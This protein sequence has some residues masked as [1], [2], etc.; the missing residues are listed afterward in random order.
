MRRLLFL[1]HINK[2]SRRFGGIFRKTHA[3]AKSALSSC[4]QTFILCPDLDK[5]SLYK[6]TSQSLILIQSFKSDD[7]K[8]NPIDFWKFCSDFLKKENFGFLYTRFSCSENFYDFTRS[9]HSI[10][11]N[12]VEFPTYPFYEECNSSDKAKFHNLV[13]RVVKH[14]TYIFSPS[15]VQRIF[16]KEVFHF[17][18]DM[19][20]TPSNFHFPIYNNKKIRVLCL[21]NFQIWHG[22]DRLLEGLANYIRN[23]KDSEIHIDFYGEG[24]MLQNLIEI[25]DSLDLNNFVKFSNF[26]DFNFFIE[27][28]CS[29][30][31]GIS[32]LGLHRIKI[33]TASPLKSRDYFSIGIPFVTTTYDQKFQNYSFAC[34]V[35]SDES[36]IDFGIILKYFRSLKKE[37]VIRDFD[38]YYARNPPWESY[39]TKLKLILEG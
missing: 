8:N 9:Y 2:K 33:E 11:V 34:K 23:T 12:I 20:Y 10:G 31:F 26:K 13:E 15:P 1:T 22:F 5:F 3:Q 29:W 37:K 21:A 27:N 39:K 28:A 32:S 17:S 14:C 25:A 6:V 16:H 30:S 18:N 4:I 36:H 35:P 7:S 38:D 24:Q 19:V